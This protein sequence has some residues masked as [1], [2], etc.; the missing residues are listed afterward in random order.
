M[1]PLLLRRQTCRMGLRP[2]GFTLIEM[3]AA[4]AIF[5]VLAAVS[6]APLKLERQRAKERELRSALS[7]IREALDRYKRMAEDGLI[8]KA[9]PGASGYP[10]SLQVLE[11]G[12]R[13]ASK[14]GSSR[15]YLLRRVPRDPMHPD[16]AMP[17]ARTWGLR[18]YA[19][20]PDSP[21]AGADVF[22]VYSL[23]EGTGLNGIRYRQW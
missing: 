16:A 1:I 2:G 3:V 15:I 17:A 19:S 11:E 4:L 18:S 5:A 13:D 20:P 7:Q 12:I 6:I 8:E 23:A 14:P 21:Q 9:G 22:D 10:S